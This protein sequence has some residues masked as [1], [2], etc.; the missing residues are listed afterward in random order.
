MSTSE[1][2]IAALRQIGTPEKAAHLSKFFKT[3]KGEY[4]EGD[5]FLG[6]PVPE[7]RRVA[8]A[9]VDTSFEDLH[10]LLESP[11]H[12]VRLCALL[13]LVERFKRKKTS[14]EERE[15]IY[16]FYLKHTKRCN[17]WDLVDLSCPTIVGGYLLNHTDRSTLYRLA[18]GPLLWEQ[19]IAMVSTYT[20]IYNR[21]FDDAIRLAKHFMTHQ[22]DLMHK[23]VGWML[24]EIGKRERPVLS[25]FLEEYAS[26]L[27][28]TALRYAIE[29]YPEEERK[30]YLKMG[31]V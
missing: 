9:H 4:G 21:Q 13:I 28:R 17:N 2:I 8:K 27:P 1:Q 20:F 29:H 12:E 15:E 25:A 18:E 7:T 14:E 22:H 3:G 10:I 31:K 19:R 11:W 5:C 6:I 23:A 24:R 26:R 16:H 30:R